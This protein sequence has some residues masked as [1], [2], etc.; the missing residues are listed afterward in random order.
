[1]RV[2]LNHLER[3]IA[4]LLEVHGVELVACEWFQGPGHGILRIT[5]DQPGGDPRLQDPARSVTLEQVTNITRDVSSA[6]DA[7]D[8]I[9]VSYTLEVGSPGP[10]RPLQKRADFDR[11]AGLS[12]RIDARDPATGAR[13]T[14]NGVLRGTV[15]LPEGR[16][17]ARI[18]VAGKTYEVPVERIARA[19]LHEIKAPSRPKPGK[20]PSRRQERLAA[21]E[22]AREINAAHR[23]A[24]AVPTAASTEAGEGT[25]PAGASPAGE[26]NPTPSKTED[27]RAPETRE[28]KR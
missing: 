15:D 21:R 13:S 16:F 1:M 9:P 5:V 8:L 10:E 27:S 12:A 24:R 11:F 3:E 7:L 22:K 23:A 6:L 2:D 25:V 20:G 26:P 17:A 18:E 19:K 28:V 4:P 14:F